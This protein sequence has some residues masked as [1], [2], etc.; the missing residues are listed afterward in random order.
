MD[1]SHE[2]ADF[3]F[4]VVPKTFIG[5]VRVEARSYTESGGN[6]HDYL[7]STSTSWITLFHLNATSCGGMTNI[8]SLD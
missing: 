2:R 3:Y 5:S 1:R 8:Q 6:H 4:E 7:N